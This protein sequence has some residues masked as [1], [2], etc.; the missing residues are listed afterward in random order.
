[1]YMRSSFYRTPLALGAA[2][3][4]L[5]GCANMDQTQS[6]TTKGAAI[7]ALGGAVLGQVI[8]GNTKGTLIGAGVGAA[9]GAI[10]GNVWSRNMQEKQRAME[11][12]TQGTGIDV[13]RT[14]DNQLK[15]EVPSDVGFAVGSAAIDPRLRP[16]LE[17][18]SQG[19]A[20]D[21]NSVIRIVGHTDSTGGAAINDPLSL[22]RA[23]SV[24]AFLQDRGIRSSR[25]ET[26][27][28]GANEP[29]ASNDTAEGRAK[30]RRVEIFLR[31]PESAQKQG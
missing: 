3:L 1:M 31:E 29:V 19:L 5:G 2:A 25:I 12:S 30:N 22:R 6:D 23:E 26:V 24:S 20:N 15:V 9:A 16:V 18:F 8:G 4:L 10:G 21:P 14:P 7:G 27:G 13:S 28:R 11:A 17:S